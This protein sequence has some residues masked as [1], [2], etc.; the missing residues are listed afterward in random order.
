MKLEMSL[1]QRQELQLKIS[2]QIIQRIEILQLPSLDLKELIE[3]EL[4]ENEILEVQEASPEDGGE[5]EIREESAPKTKEVETSFETLENIEDWDEYLPTRVKRKWDDQEKDKKMEAI[6]NIA[7]K[8]STLHDYLFSQF[9]LV[10]CPPLVKEAG[11]YIIYNIDSNGFLQYSLEEIL[12]SIEEKN[13]FGLKD[14]QDALSIIQTLEPSGVGGRNSQECLILQLDRKDPY[15]HLK[16]RLLEEFLE[17]IKKNRLPKIAK[18]TGEDIET[19]KE[20][21][22]FIG[23]L[24]PK[25][26][27]AFS[28]ETIHYINPDVLLEWVDGEYEIRLEDNFF[29]TLRIS[30]R[31]REMYENEKKNS[32][33]REYIK[34]KLESARLLIEAIEQRKNTLY[35]V[36]REIVNRQ[37]DFLDY[38][39][40][41]L[42]P[43]KMQEIADSLGIDVST[44][45]RAIAEKYI[46]T[47]RG[48]FPIKFF[49]TG[50]IEGTSGV[51]E[52]RVSVKQKVKEIIEKEDRKAPLSDDEIANLLKAQGLDIARRTVT[53]YRKSL[54]IPS[55]RQRREY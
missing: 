1:H 21:I 30:P 35:R 34:K 37:R 33:V 15:Y 32:K 51:S 48:I 31:Y 28:R 3:K 24:N 22:A 17:D 14:A 26:G 54:K 18:E 8:P 46:Q 47:H 2:P 6:Q 44:V 29:P 16:R 52:S 38:G 41:H 12:E 45:S 50:A 25:P 13:S 7:S 11:K 36:C 42:K 9:S 40:N 55:S 19:I 4:L 27:S 53:K 20:M 10:D 43:L 5:K 49:F 23:T 39:I